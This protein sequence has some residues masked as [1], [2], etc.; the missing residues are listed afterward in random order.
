MRSINKLIQ[1]LILSS[2]ENDLCEIQVE[3]YDKETEK[4][5]SSKLVSESP[6]LLAEDMIVPFLKIVRDEDECFGLPYSLKAIYDRGE[7]FVSSKPEMFVGGRA[8]HIAIS[9]RNLSTPPSLKKKEYDIY[10]AEIE[11][12][13]MEG[14]S[15]SWKCT[16]GISETEFGKEYSVESREYHLGKLAWLLELVNEFISN[17][18]YD[19]VDMRLPEAVGHYRAVEV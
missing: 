12:F 17:A 10:T 3:R 6:F 1:K 14:A 9:V 19:D 5:I 8:D 4:M 2:V 18:I 7:L 15:S 13:E 11:M 16:L